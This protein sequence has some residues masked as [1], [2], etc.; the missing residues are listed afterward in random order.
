MLYAL[1][2]RLLELARGH[3]LALLV[4]KAFGEEVFQGEDPEVGLYVFAVHHAGDGGNVKACTLR[5]VFEH[6]R[7]QLGFVPV[8][9]IV[10]LELYY[11]VHS[12]LKGVE[13]LLEGLYKALCGVNLLLDEACRLLVLLAVGILGGLEHI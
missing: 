7:A 10:V 6:H 2:E 4:L 3:L 8:Y 5:N 11:G 13:T 12:G 9:E 1:S